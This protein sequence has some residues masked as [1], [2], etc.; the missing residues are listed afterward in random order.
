MKILYVISGITGMTGNELVSQ[1]LNQTDDEVR[2]IGFDNF[3]A[4]SIDTIKDYLDDDRL[5]FYEYDL[6]NKEEM[7]KIKSMVL[8]IREDFDELIYINCAAVVHTEHFYN[9]Y[10][11]YQTNVVSM[12][13]FLSQAIEIGAEKFINCSTSEVYSMNSWN[14]S[15]GEVNSRTFMELLRL[16]KRIE[17]AEARSRRR[18]TFAYAVAIAASLVAVVSATFLLTRNEYAVSPLDSTR[19]LVAAYGQISSIKLEDGTMV[20]LNSGSTL[21]YPASFKNGS[22]I[23]YLT[24]EG[25]FDVAKDPDRPFIVKTS[26]M[27]VQALGTSFCV[28]SFV[29]DRDVRT[30]LKEGKV[31]VDVHS[32]EGKSYILDP[33]MQ[34][35]YTPSRKNVFLAM[36]DAERVMSWQ[37]GYLTFNNASFPEVASALERRFNV[38]I[39]YNSENLKKNALNVRFVPDET[40]EDA[41]GVLTLLLPG[42]R[43]RIEGERVYFHF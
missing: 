18:R 15:G 16:G 24:G 6:N 31:K 11:T 12:N 41:L 38:S 21:L 40:L 39:S 13:D 29:G 36:V 43:Y 30:T 3:Y 1:L 17:V 22:R 10:E 19:N 20:H 8:D 14:E 26:Y 7:D 25:N 35:V 27:D 34:L 37:N 23:V 2:I 5:D 42:S 28:Q 9:V 33:G 4:S 32:G